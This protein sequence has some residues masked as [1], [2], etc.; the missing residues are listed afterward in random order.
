MP[1]NTKRPNIVFFMVDQLSAKWLEAASDGVCLTPNIDRLR[2]MG[3]T[4]THAFTSNPVCMPMRATLATGL[5]TR[6][7]GVLENG[8]QL[9]PTLPTFMQALQSAGWRTGALGKVH[10]YP[11]FRGLRPDYR[12]F[13]FDVTHITED[14]RGGEWL[15]WVEEE[16]PEHYE[17][18]LATIWPT[19][20]PEFA[21]YGPER[22]DLRARID[23]IR[24]G[25]EWATPDFP[26]NDGFAYTLPFPEPVSQTA[27]ITQHAL[28]FI[29]ETDPDRPLYAH[30]SYVQPHSPFHPPAEYMQYVDVSKIPEPAPAEWVHDPHA[31]GYFCDKTPVDRDWQYA[32]HCY[33]ADIVHLD[34]QLGKVLDALEAAGRLDN[35]YLF[36]LS[37]HGEL[38]CDHGFVGKEERH[39]DAC[40]R[41]PLIIA[42][43]GLQ[44]GQVCDQLVQHED[45]CPTVLEACSVSLPPLP[46]TGPYLKVEQQDIVSLPGRSLLGLCRGEEPDAWRD[47]AYSESYNA[48]WSITPGD[49]ARTIRTRDFRYT[50]YAAGNGEQMFDLRTDPDE[51]HNVVA[52]PAY[53]TTRRELCDRLLELIVLQDYPKPRREL[54]AL[55]V[56]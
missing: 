55:G 45:L 1:T 41:V 14:A 26:R 44:R 13:G 18:V 54:F 38:L 52:D 50:F 2:E 27:W 23:A 42:G 15:D 39:Y 47:E 5:T 46:K 36:F 3:T 10:L 24:E 35:A 32:R 34:R 7:H 21:A 37:D 12:P 19:A 31:P 40:I 25:F 4:F 33:F 48:I 11:H 43:P 17:S 6:G 9:D 53:A 51:Q 22:V 8:Y 29:E 49:W 56:H 28:A 30:I 20:I 16:Y